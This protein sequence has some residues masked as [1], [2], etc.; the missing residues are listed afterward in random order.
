MK[1]CILTSL[2]LPF[3]V[4]LSL[5]S[6]AQAA[7]YFQNFNV[8][9]GTSSLGDGS[10]L[11]AGTDPANQAASVQNSGLPGA[12]PALQLTS[13]TGFSTQNSFNIPALSNSSHGF[14]VSFDVTLIDTA[15][16]NSPA[17][18]FSFN[19][20]NFGS[21]ANYG[22]EGPGAGSISWVVDTWDNGLAD[23]GYRSRINGVNDFVQ[24]LV[25]LADGQ[26]LTTFVNLSWNPVNGMNMSIG[27]T[28]IFTDRPTPGFT[29]S[30]SNLFGIGAR[31]GGAT[32]TVLIDNLIIT[33]VPEA[34]GAS[35]II[36]S[37]L[38]VTLVRRRRDSRA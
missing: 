13:T 20:G 25:P 14:I 10:V 26:T 8:P 5:N 29:G 32:E 15:G 18:G 21:A 3:A 7:V 28:P 27:G 19:Y 9:S 17:D 2:C 12:T 22:E 6:G 31:T 33:T 16:G 37:G 23:Q 4:S 11:T 24:N 38:G 30:D 35:L 1:S 34:T 36:L